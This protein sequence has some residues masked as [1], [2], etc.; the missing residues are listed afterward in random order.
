MTEQDF[1]RELEGLGEDLSNLDNLLLELAGQI[2]NETKAGAPVDTGALRN[3]IQARIE[4][5]SVLVE[6]LYYGMFQNYGVNGT[7]TQFGL[8]VPDGV[9]LRPTSEPFYK[10]KER[11]FGI[12]PQTFFNI[13]AISDRITE[14]I[15]NRFEQ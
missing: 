10:F 3:S 1:I 14:A 7:E 8:P 12:V 4:N 13:D 6:M 2:V 9:G 5:G 11:R 15:A